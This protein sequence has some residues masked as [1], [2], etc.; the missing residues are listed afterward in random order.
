MKKCK[1]CDGVGVVNR[2]VQLA[3]GFITQSRA[4]CP[5]CKGQGESVDKSK[6]CQ[7]CQG[8]KVTA[9]K[10]TLEVHIDKGM[11]M[12]QKVVFEGEADERP[13]VQ[14]GDVIFI[15]QEKQHQMFQREDKN[16]ICQKKIS[17]VEALTGV[18]FKL[19]HLDGR[20]LLVK[21]FA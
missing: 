4:H 11:K 13:G 6:I 15:L 5:D 2:V 16:L 12:G 1:T 3:P 19:T 9:E 7:A 10:K 18:E 14:P 20:I 8:N 21:R 17:L